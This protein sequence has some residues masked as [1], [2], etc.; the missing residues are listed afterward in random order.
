MNANE[1]NV[2][3]VMSRRRSVRRFDSRNI[4]ENVLV[5]ILEAATHAP[6]A[7]NRQTWRFVVLDDLTTRAKLV[8]VMSKDY[9][10]AM[11][12]EGVAPDKVE[13]RV[14]SRGERVND[15]PKAVMICVDMNELDAYDND[16][17]QDGEYLMAVQSVAMAGDH[18]LLAAHSLGL[19][20]VWMCAPLFVQQK[21]RDALDLPESWLAQG[22][23]LLG[24]PAEERP[25]K[26]RKELGQVVVYK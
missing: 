12:A 19:G 13:A 16:L 15:A 4:E 14:N 21:V 26:P 25:K 11:L 8:D 9:R 24:Y 18:L 1:N 20:G 5:K 17:R 7:H 23:I 22:L 2:L 10:A 6:N 3:E